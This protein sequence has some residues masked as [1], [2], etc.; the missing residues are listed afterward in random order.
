MGI[1]PNNGKLRLLSLISAIHFH[2]TTKH[3]TPKAIALKIFT[4]LNV[5]GSDKS[6]SRF[7][8]S[9]HAVVSF[10]ASSTMAEPK[11]DTAVCGCLKCSIKASW[12]GPLGRG[13]SAFSATTHPFLAG[14][15]NGFALSSILA[16]LIQP[17]STKSSRIARIT[18]VFPPRK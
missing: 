6:C 13:N 12:T 7:A 2:R 17:R 16:S 11:T 5:F 8:Q 18:S 9:R 14:F 10:L 15:D 1:A 3:R 4:S